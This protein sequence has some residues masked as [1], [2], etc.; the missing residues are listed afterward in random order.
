VCKGGP[1]DAV[2]IGE[3]TVLLEGQMAA[4]FGDGTAHA[5]L[6]DA[7]CP[8]VVIG[9]MTAADKRMRYME[10]LKLIAAARAK[11]ASMPNG[12]EK[13]RLSQA[14]ERLASNNQVVEDA[15]LAK[16]VYNTQGAPEGWH[17]LTPDELPDSLKN[18]TFHD[19]SSGF[20]AELY[21]SEIDG[22]YRLVYRGT[23][24]ETFK[25][26][27]GNDWL[28]GNTQGAGIPATQYSQA[29]DLARQVGA[30]YGDNVT[31]TGHSLGGGLASAGALASGR[32]ANTFNAAGLSPMTYHWYGL[33]K[34]QAGTLVDAYQTDGEILT[35]LQEHSPV[36][37]AMPD[38]IGNKHPLPAVN[39]TQ[40]PDG[41]YSFSPRPDA[42]KA[43]EAAPRHWYDWINP[44]D[45]FNRAKDWVKGQIDEKSAWA[46][47]ATTRH[48]M[49][50]EGV[51][52]QK[53][54]DTATLK[55]ML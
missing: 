17:R 50:I 6:I 16:D 13:D 43:P 28:W 51:E 38:A 20:Y 11:A 4:R 54:D 8:T 1:L 22:S 14:A 23:E 34:N 49:H 15:K 7:G 41:S 47:E 46:K 44:V 42:P 21:R 55:G 19:P 18:A 37:G 9:Q 35:Q 25:Q 48:G 2:T 5:G 26:W 27:Q 3:P 31:L 12:P 53:A 29:V 33:D 40:N 52:S 36:S 10:R 30:T 32:H 39:M 45:Q 24:F